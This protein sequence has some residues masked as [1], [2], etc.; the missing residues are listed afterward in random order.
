MMNVT[1]PEPPDLTRLDALIDAE[2]DAKQ[3]D[4]YRAVRLALAGGEAHAV[5]ATVG[6]RRTVVQTWAY[7]Y[8]DG[9]LAALTP[10]K[11]PGRRP[12]LTADQRASF[13]V[14]VLAGPTDADRGRVRVPGRGLPP[15][16]GTRVRRGPLAPVGVRPARP[17]AAVAPSAAAPPPQERPV[18]GRGVPGRRPPFVAGQRAGRPG[19]RVARWFQDEARIGPQ[20]TLTHG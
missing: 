10:R 9:G 3:R 6:R 19:K 20:G 7:G 15:H 14:R 2:R 12:A 17:A 5:A 16:F 4:R 8:R 11:Q 1:A 13:R 18:G